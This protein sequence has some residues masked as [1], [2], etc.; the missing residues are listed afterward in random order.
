MSKSQSG[1]DHTVRPALGGRPSKVFCL[2]GFVAAA[3]LVFWW[4]HTAGFSDDSTIRHTTTAKIYRRVG[5]PPGITATDAPPTRLSELWNPVPQHIATQ[6]TS[7]AVLHRVLRQIGATSESDAQEATLNIAAV[8]K[9]LQVTVGKA[10]E[11]GE[12]EIAI[13]YTDSDADRCVRLVNR[14]AESYAAD[15][16]TQWQSRAREV[17]VET[18]NATEIARRTLLESQQQLDALADRQTDDMSA[19]APLTPRAERPGT[20]ETSKQVESAWP[21][22][23]EEEPAK[24]DSPE[25]LELQN[26]LARVKSHRDILLIDRTALHSEVQEAEMQISELEQRIASISSPDTGASADDLSLPSPQRS[27]ADLTDVRM[28]TEPP[29]NDPAASLAAQRRANMLE[30]LRELERTVKEAD[31]AYQIAARR[32]RQAWETGQLAPRIEVDL[33]RMVDAPAPQGPGLTILLATLIAG[34][35]G[36]A[37]TGMVS[38]GW[39]MEPALNTVAEVGKAISVPVVGVVSQSGLPSDQPESGDQRQWLRPILILG[40]LILIGGCVTMAINMLGM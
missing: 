22:I 24:V 35:A 27:A 32:E 11:P 36:A 37:G 25:R 39:A 14:L 20:Q 13:K 31:E 28:P 2:L 12:L 7:E 3:S 17:C 9:N 29:P 26:E 16:R 10:T 33:A 19:D 23:A 18:G 8:R 1:S 4:G 30:K 34:I 21:R 40:G 5:F 6:I 15:L 38:L